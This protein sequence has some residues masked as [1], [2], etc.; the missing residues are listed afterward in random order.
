MLAPAVAPLLI[1]VLFSL[2]P[3]YEPLSVL[4]IPIGAFTYAVA[5]LLGLPVLVALRK[6]RWLSAWQFA[7]AGAILGLAP[8]GFF[9]LIAVSVSRSPP[10]GLP[11]LYREAGGYVHL[12]VW[13]LPDLLVLL[14]LAP[15]QSSGEQ[16]PFPSMALGAGLGFC[17]STISAHG[18]ARWPL[19][20]RCRLCVL[21]G[22]GG[23]FLSQ[24]WACALGSGYFGLGRSVATVAGTGK[25]H[26]RRARSRP[27]AQP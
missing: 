27:R 22:L 26:Q 23:P 17:A 18:S 7:L 14:E 9:M 20:S 21:Y 25:P 19:W 24:L 6:L 3:G 5:L 13:A 1:F 4:A 12:H 11:G 8:L 2:L 15:N 16:A 10:C